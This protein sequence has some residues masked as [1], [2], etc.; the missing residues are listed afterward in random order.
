MRKTLLFAA[1]GLM[2]LA[3]CSS[4]K[5]V[6][7]AADFSAQTA[8]HQKIAVLPIRVV[9]TG[10]V[11]KKE[12]PESIRAA[13]EAWSLQFQETLLSYVVSKAGKRRKGPMVTFQ[14]APQTNSLLAAAGLDIE[15]AYGQSPDSLAK[16]LGVDAVIMTTL[17]KRKNV[18]DG[19][20]TAIGAGRDILRVLNTGAP[21]NTI[22]SDFNATDINMNSTLYG[23]DG[24][25]LWK[26]FR[27]GGEDLPK[28]VN[29]L[30]QY[31][32]NWIAKKLPYRA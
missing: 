4:S 12:N 7:R 11:G 27:E 20:A 30:V 10:W 31:Y 18:S 2:A 28:N 26:T 22:L 25:M 21:G 9:Q 16:V 19:V 6:Y 13:N 32:S 15:K 5:N 23:R 29:E 24:R 3:S 14:G 17:D 1:I 8:T